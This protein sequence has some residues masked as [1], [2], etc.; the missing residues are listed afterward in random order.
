MA[1]TWDDIRNGADGWLGVIL[2]P[3]PTGAN[4]RLEPD[5][6]AVE[7]E[8]AK[9]D[10]P[11]GGEVSW[12]QVLQLGGILLRTRTKDLTVASW[13]AH[14]LHV[15][16]G[17]AGLQ[18][19]MVLLAEMESRYWDGMFPEAKRLRA[20][21]NAL[22][23]YLERTVRSL[24]TTRSEPS[25]AELEGLEVAA[26]RLAEISRERLGDAAPAFGS[27]L[28]QVQRLKLSAAPSPPPPAAPQPSPVPTTP[29]APAAAVPRAA[30]VLPAPPL[31]AAPGQLGDAA[32][33]T[34]WLGQVGSALISAAGL[35]RRAN[36]A[37][38]APYR[39]LRVGLWLHLAAAPASSGGKTQI[40]PPPEPLR[41]QLA[42]LGQNQK[43]AEL[44]EETEAAAAQHRLW[45]D[46]HRMSWQALGGLGREGARGAVT[47]EVRAL[48][49][50]MPQLPTLAFVNGSPLANAQTRAWLDELG[51]TGRAEA[52]AAAASGG[53]GSSAAALAQ[54]RKLL[55]A[56]QAS[57]ALTMLQEA[58]A[59][60]PGGRERF[61]LRLE[62]ARL[63][64]GAGLT[65]LAKATY[66]DL[67]RDG[68]A[69]G[70]DRWEPALAAECLKGL[71]ASVRA[72]SKDPRGAL[73]DLAEPYRRLCRLDPAAAHEVWP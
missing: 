19:G 2:G 14:A 47:A 34:E 1:L 26:T 54:A 25:A 20:R 58:V 66:E 45:L 70:L 10:A 6:Q 67:D 71:L 65:A 57:Q 37:E 50:R 43:W 52:A 38:A 55:G 46:L 11:A 28:E 62:L 22:Q 8:V 56:G 18:I 68:A 33:A 49:A 63:F 31:P 9:I 12:K 41:N 17:F 53:G 29:P 40:P 30:A 64:V 27:L 72:L 3:S 69:H 73:P 42:L 13:L 15:T 61:R 4:V 5:Y 16:Q 24:G 23:W 51:G 21:A 59:A 39:L 48:L 36:E 7:A 60:V 32:A 44:L 35:L